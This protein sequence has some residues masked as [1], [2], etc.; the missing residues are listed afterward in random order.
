MFYITI[1]TGFVYLGIVLEENIFKILGISLALTGISTH[2][3]FTHSLV[4][5]F[6]FSWVAYLCSE[7]F[8]LDEMY[9]GFNIGYVLHLIMDFFTP[10]GIQLFFPITK[11]ISSPITIRTKGGGESLIFI[12]SSFYSLYFLIQLIK[13]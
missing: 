4:G 13:T 2:R 1:G 3:G 6:I 9:L 10:Q 5:F 11:F 8:G 12:G 7:K